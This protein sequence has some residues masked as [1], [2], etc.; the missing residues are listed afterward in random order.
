ML[1]IKTI[2]RDTT[3]KTFSNLIDI[4][5]L[6]KTLQINDEKGKEKAII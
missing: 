4:F 1:D 2:W 6:E 5:K 3:S